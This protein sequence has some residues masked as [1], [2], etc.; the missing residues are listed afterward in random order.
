M[1]CQ[2][3]AIAV[4]NAA[5][6]EAVYE[7]AGSTCKYP[8][9]LDKCVAYQIALPVVPEMAGKAKLYLPMPMMKEKQLLKEIHDQCADKTEELLKAGQNVAFI[10]LGDPSVYST[11]LY[12]HKRLKKRGCETRLIPGIPSFCAAAARM[13]IGLVENKDELHVIPASYGIEESLNMSGTK[14]L[15]KA[16]KK[17]PYVKE[18]VKEK[19]LQ[20]EMVENCGMPDERIYRNIDDV[21][22]EAS[23]YSLM[24]IKEER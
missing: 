22:D 20:I 24:I 5:L 16:G 14:V 10:T 12:V 2:V 8:E 11:A 3:V 1:N 15:M 4:A 6:K 17:M 21:P 7:E 23:Y 13:D 9:Y 18:Q 19:K